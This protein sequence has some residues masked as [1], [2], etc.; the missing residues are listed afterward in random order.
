MLTMKGVVLL[1]AIV[2]VDQDGLACDA[3]SNAQMG[4]MEVVVRD[5][6]N[7]GTARHVIISPVNAFVVP[8]G[9][10][11]TVT[12]R[13]PTR[14]MG[15]DVAGFVNAGITPRV[16]TSQVRASARQVGLVETATS[17][18]LRV[19][20]DLDVRKFVDAR[21]EGPVIR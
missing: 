3:R 9:R 13:V 14:P 4:G 5:C 1:K 18:V 17:C 2:T 7:V 12:F 15:T 8:V 6:V 11:S 21:M 20:S 19:S 16:I 10:E